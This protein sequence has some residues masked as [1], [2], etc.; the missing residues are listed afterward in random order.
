ML[1]IGSPLIKVFYLPAVYIKT[2]D[3]K[4]F[5]TEPQDERQADVAKTYDA[6]PCRTVFYLRDEFLINHICSPLFTGQAA[7]IPVCTRILDLRLR[8]LNFMSYCKKQIL[9]SSTLYF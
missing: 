3:L 1:Y 2:C 7:A 5:L 9:F 4:P 8:L 6:N